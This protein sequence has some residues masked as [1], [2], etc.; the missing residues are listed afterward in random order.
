M[1]TRNK[2]KRPADSRVYTRAGDGPGESPFA[3]VPAEKRARMLADLETQGREFA[4]QAE[5]QASR[6]DAIRHGVKTERD[7]QPVQVRMLTSQIKVLKQIAE[8]ENR[9]S[10]DVIREL[11]HGYIQHCLDTW[12]DD[13]AKLI[14]KATAR[15]SGYLKDMDRVA[16]SPETGPKRSE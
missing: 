14:L 4:A 12:T 3:N 7:T 10:S 5:K 9:S 11:V 15:Q 1:A 2:I 16:V 13:D 6:V 8:Q